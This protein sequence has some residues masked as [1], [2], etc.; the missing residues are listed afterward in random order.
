MSDK[1]TAQLVP[2]KATDGVRSPSQES[3]ALFQGRTENSLFGLQQ[4]LGNQAMLRLLASG[5]VRAKLRVSQP[6]DADEQE[7]DR[8][9]DQVVTAMRAPK[10]QRKCDCG[11]TCA[12]CAE[13]ENATI[14]R[15]V[16]S[17]LVRSSQLGI[18]RAPAE[19][20]PAETTPETHHRKHKTH[21][22]ALHSF[23][24]DDEA[25]E[26]Q[27]RQMR[28]SQFIA[29]LRTDA[30]AAADAVLASVKHSTKACPYVEKWLSFY[31]KQ[32]ASHIESALH[33]YA[34]ET[35]KARSA[36]EAIRM[37]VVRIQKA[38]FT[39]A[40]TGKIEGLPDELAKQIPGHG[41]LLEKLHNF[42]STGVA[43]AI[44]GFIGG[45]GGHASDSGTGSGGKSTHKED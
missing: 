23:V 6:G 10:I 15:S 29:L 3:T 9:A 7:A 27:P 19:Q 24:V 28:K 12:S 34:P 16:V 43:G 30:C 22:P 17:P 2:S 11:G 13:E 41:G 39:W 32:S 31:E 25:K 35:A 20:A 45:K 40:K 5:A 4:A 37:V 14:H 44:F 1:V 33:K 42:A 26:I 36:H 21:T 8:A 18:Q 38:A